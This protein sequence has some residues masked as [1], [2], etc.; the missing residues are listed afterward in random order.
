MK[1][2][3]PTRE[4]TRARIMDQADALF[5]QFGYTKTTVA[6]IAREL[7]MSPANIYKFFPSKSAIIQAGADRNLC[8]IKENLTRVA[9]A[10]KGAANRLLDVILSIYRVHQDYF[11]HER[12]IYKLVI[13]ATEENWSCVRLFKEF[14]TGILKDLLE[15][16]IRTG[17]FCRMDSAATTGVLL[18]CFTW[19]T[20]PILFQEL[21]PSEVESR[22]RA[23]VQLLKKALQ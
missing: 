13:A 5:R 22:A 9:R 3:R 17:E 7:D 20:N 14:L 23:Q 11:R 6:D 10:K 2:H 12:Q 18:D 16:G 19:I 15:D 8:Q 1:N 4:Q 21:N